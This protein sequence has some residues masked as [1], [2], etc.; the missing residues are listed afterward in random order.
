MNTKFSTARYLILAALITT[1]IFAFLTASY[2]GR[3]W[4]DG[5]TDDSNSPPG[6]L[7]SD[8]EDYWGESVLTGVDYKYEVAPDSPADNRVDRVGRTGRVLLN[9]NRGT[10]VGM[11]GDKPLVVTFDFKRL[12]TF[13]ELDFCT[14]SGKLS[15]KIETSAGEDGQW[16]TAF[17]R[18]IDDCPDAKFHR[19]PL[20]EKPEG[21]FVRLTLLGASGTELDEVVAWGDAEV[22]DSAPEAINPV[23]EGQ[24]PVGVSYETIK[25]ITKSFVS[26]RESFYWVQSLAPEHKKQHAVWAQVPTWSSISGAA[27][28]PDP[29]DVN[30]PINIV[31]ARNETECVALALK[32]TLVD[33][34][35]DVE[36][37]MSRFQ[38]SSGGD[39]DG[40]TG[41]LSVFGVIG[42]RN[43]GNNLGPIFE[44]DN[45][46][47]KSLMQ[48]YLLN[49][50]LIKDFPA[51]KLSPSGAAVLW[52]SVNTEGAKP[53]VYKAYL[54]IKGG[55]A[56]PVKVEVLDVTLP[57]P[58]A[59]VG[60]Y[61]GNVTNMFPFV[62]SD[63]EE[64]DI[65]YALRCGISKWGYSKLVQKMAKER[66]MKMMYEIGAL[67]PSIYM[68]NVYCG[69]WT[70]E[71]DF[72]EKHEQEVAEHIK[73]VVQRA[74]SLG[75]SYDEWFGITGDEP[76]EG[77]IAAVAAM[78][79]LIKK[80]DPNVNIYVN[81][82]YW[83]GFDDG[84]V[85][86]DHIV[87]KGLQRWYSKHVDISMPLV[88]LLQG[89]PQSWKEFSAPRLV[90]SYYLVSGH[91][92]RS[93]QAA[94]VQLYRKYAWDSFSWG[95][96]GW[97]FYSY[98]SPRGSAWNHFDRSPVGEGFHEPS[99]YSIVYP[100]PR[101]VIP[102]RQ[103]EALREGYEDWC[104]LN[105]L[106]EK[107]KSADLQRVLK[108]YQ[109]GKPM[110]ELRTL[111]LRAA[112]SR[113]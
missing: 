94:E 15:I 37:T 71:S 99:D 107:G 41:K 3:V 95:F 2:A 61:S 16:V 57:K 103:S 92:G 49:G 33:G 108:G 8:N 80:A 76:H 25:G 81:P 7:L 51:V 88:L 100:G 97:A 43:F 19:L 106:K 69:I 101:R 6:K 91:L 44:A 31:M 29:K 62:Y 82:A 54:Q 42:S 66:G 26:D 68:D 22:S 112:A 111:A 40:L 104:L 84:G 28:L 13:S 58:F 4:W 46:L 77:N 36:V 56:V 23:T 70:K 105:L 9:G 11:S 12:C 32:N 59:L 79:K 39:A 18:G 1:I 113:K 27:I 48:K 52:L 86:S 5:S 55:E 85:A 93:E 73:G 87:K 35:R 109:Q 83:I 90:N 72:G 47:G 50:D 74:K 10:G 38:T 34:V 17:D 63:R 30:R 14:P 60:T 110:D 102:T 89:R 20:P 53:G 67:V 96:N 75:L 24:Y 45:L 64:Q 65:D 78:C 98:Y 21:R